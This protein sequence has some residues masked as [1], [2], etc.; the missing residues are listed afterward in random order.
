MWNSGN[1]IQS[2]DDSVVC[3]QGGDLNLQRAQKLG[4]FAVLS[5]I[6]GF[7]LALTAEA[8]GQRTVA[9]PRPPS[10]AAS[11]GTAPQNCPIASPR[12]IHQVR[13]TTV[14]IWVGSGA[15]RGN[16]GWYIANGRLALGFGAR[17]HYGYPQKVFWQ[18]I[19]G[20]R[21]PVALNGWNL[22]TGQRIWFGHPV[23]PDPDHH[24]IAWPAAIVRHHRAPTL[25]FVPSAGCYRLHAQWSGGSWTIPFTAGG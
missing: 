11:F 12:M 19:N 3:I 21:D 17:T 13:A 23:L 16:T 24:L 7:S 1:T 8:A 6:F 14:Y 10:I 20:S 5:L 15:L 18:L 4:L 25:M 22:R 2:S 9:A